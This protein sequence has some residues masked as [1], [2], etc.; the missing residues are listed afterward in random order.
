ML[1]HKTFST[2]SSQS[3]DRRRRLLLLL[4]LNFEGLE[5]EG[6]KVTYSDRRCLCGL[7]VIRSRDMGGYIPSSLFFNLFALAYFSCKISLVYIR[8]LFPVFFTI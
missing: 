4:F 1:V 6:K 8:H 2:L 5:A 3:L 7:A